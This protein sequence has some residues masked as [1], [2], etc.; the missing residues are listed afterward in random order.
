MQRPV[1]S[2]FLVGGGG[3]CVTRCVNKQTRCG[4][5]Q[6]EETKERGSINSG[7]HTLKQVGGPT[8]VG[9]AGRVGSARHLYMLGDMFTSAKHEPELP[10]QDVFRHV[11][12]F[13]AGNAGD[14]C[15]AKNEKY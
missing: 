2:F 7:L 14:L 9:R 4:P 3:G 11:A 8:L 12:M 15:S 10:L 13:V 5:L 1:L 6:S